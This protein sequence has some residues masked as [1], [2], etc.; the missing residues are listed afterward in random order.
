MAN[1]TVRVE[2][3]DANSKDYEKLH[4]K[5]ENAGFERTITTT[6]GKIYHLPDAEYSITSDKSTDE[7]KD[8]A[9][10]TAKKVK[11]N[12]AILVTKSSGTRRWSGLDEG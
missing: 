3:H 1:F 7:I 12:P 8:L 2:L 6:S 5:M 10:D 9:R 4:E 11:S